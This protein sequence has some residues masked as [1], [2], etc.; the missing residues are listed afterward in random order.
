MGWSQRLFGVLRRALSKEVKEQVGTDRFGNKYYY[1]PEY[2]NWR[3]QTIREKRIV[4]AANKREIDYEVGDIPTEWEGDICPGASTATKGHRSQPV[5]HSHVDA[6][7]WKDP[8]LHTC[9]CWQHPVS[10][11]CRAV[12]NSFSLDVGQRPP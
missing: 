3:G 1:I 11:G 12:R 10:H 8:L 2:K 9:S 6:Q 4:E 5:S 7:V